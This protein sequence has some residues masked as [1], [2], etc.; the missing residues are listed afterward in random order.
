MFEFITDEAIRAQA[1][2]AHDTT[3]KGITE[4]LDAKVDEAVSGL[5]S[6]NAELLDEKKKIQESLKDFDGVD[7]GKAKEA[8][9]FLEGNVDAQLIRD[10]KIDELLDKRTSTLRSDHESAI[11]ELQ[12]TLD[13]SNGKATTYEGLYKSKMIEDSLREA[14]T[15]GKVRP[16]A[17][18]DILLRGRNVFSLAEDGSVEARDADGK[19]A[20]TEGGSVLSPSNWIDGLKKSSPHYWPGSE[21]VGAQGGGAGGEGD[22]TA[23]LNRAASSNNMVEY[24]RLRAKQQGKK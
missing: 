17:I 21:G 20:K 2:E 22:L 10:G 8:L 11:T 24:R 14:A 1:V 4:G 6:K 5:K 19:L 12:K 7:P 18:P 3:M 13:E 23:A 15:T 16:E 9:L